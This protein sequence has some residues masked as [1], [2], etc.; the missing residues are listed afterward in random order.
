MEL[1]MN[2][3]SATIARTWGITRAQHAHKRTKTSQEGVQMLQVVPETT[4]EAVEDQYL[5]E[6][7]F[8]NV[9]EKSDDFLFRQSD[10]RYDIIPSS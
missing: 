7:T 6:F 5:S 10:T 8:V 2:E 9:Q 4:V 1:C 3:S